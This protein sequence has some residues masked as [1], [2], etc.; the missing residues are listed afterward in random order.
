MIL[1]ACPHCEKRIVGSDKFAGQYRECPNC[2]D[3]FV[4][5]P[6]NDDGFTNDSKAVSGDGEIRLP[7]AWK[8]PEVMKPAEFRIEAQSP[9][10]ENGTAVFEEDIPVGSVAKVEAVSFAASIPEIRLKTEAAGSIESDHPSLWMQS[11]QSKESRSCLIST[12]LH[13]VLL[14]ETKPPGLITV[15]PDNMVDQRVDTF[16]FDAA[17]EEVAIK[18][19]EPVA[20]VEVATADEPDL[21]EASRIGNL[22]SLD[23]KP[24]KPEE[25]KSKSSKEKSRGEPG[26]EPTEATVRQAISVEAA[27]DTIIELIKSKLL[28]QDTAVI[29]LM[30]R[31]VSMQR[32]RSML[33]DRLE[34]YLNEVHETRT[35]GSHSLMHIVV[36]FGDRFEKLVVTLEP[37]R[38]LTAIRKDYKLDP[39]GKENVFSAIEWCE[40]QFV[41]KNGKNRQKHLMCV[42][43]TDESGDDYLRLEQ[44]IQICSGSRLEVS[45]IGPSAVL[46]QMRGYHA[47]TANDNQLYYLPV[48]RGPDTALLQRIKLPYWFRKVPIHWDEARRGPWY[49]NTPAWQGGSNYDAMLSGFGPYALTRLTMATGGDYILYDRPSDSSPFKIE[50]MRPYLPDYRKA[51]AI[52]ADLYEKPLRMTILKAVEASHQLNLHVLRLDYGVQYGGLFYY[53]PQEF[54]AKVRAAVVAE[55]PRAEAAVLALDQMIG[56]FE[57]RAVDGLY[58]NETSPRWKAW[59]DLTY[60]RLLAARVRY[61]VF[62]EFA[63]NFSAARF[64]STKN[65]FSLRP[66]KLSETRRRLTREADARV[67]LN[68]CMFSNLETPWFYLARRELKHNFGLA[69]EERSVIRAPRGRGTRSLK[70]SLPQL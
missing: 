45:V 23:A 42:V 65:G 7:P 26:P 43:C 61:Q 9:L 57:N 1:V 8:Q 49:G 24:E 39:T 32:Q 47:Y 48:V 25:T 29:W 33:A 44:T 19:P 50:T 55:K 12:A 21:F 6:V 51:N 17:P 40:D 20:P 5:L 16:E 14:P 36:A 38:A 3:L 37:R 64:K 22:L 69:V 13:A 15:L 46:G 66:A 30:D 59:Y 28:E 11:L 60:G 54:Q 58:E 4:V 34:G 52:Q 53:S 35:D 67:I 62:I 41:R 70:V 27:T 31:S 56:L 63:A 10:P 18:P 2:G 68:R